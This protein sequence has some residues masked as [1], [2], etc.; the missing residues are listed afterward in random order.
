MIVVKCE[1]K[2]WQEGRTDQKAEEE[3]ERERRK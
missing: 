2:G 1:N 3:R